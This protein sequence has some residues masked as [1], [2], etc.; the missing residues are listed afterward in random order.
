MLL[1]KIH[2]GRSSGV[3]RNLAKVEV[4]SSNLIARS[5]FLPVFSPCF[6]SVS[7]VREIDDA[8]FHVTFHDPAFVMAPSLAY[9]HQI[10]VV[11]AAMA[12]VAIGE[13]KS[14]LAMPVVVR[15]L[16]LI[17]IAVGVPNLTVAVQFS[18]I[19]VAPVS[20]PVGP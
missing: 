5:N 6:Q 15:P 8:A 20:A 14:A 18:V 4:V 16:T 10:I 17:P 7:S 3:E 11:P 13:Q 12:F 1:Q 9:S 2:C 19:P